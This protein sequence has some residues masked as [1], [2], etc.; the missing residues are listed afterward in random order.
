M[1]P[2]MSRMPADK[3]QE[4]RCL[5]LF[6]LAWRFNG[7]EKT[8]QWHLTHFKEFG[9]SFTF[10]KDKLSTET[11]AFDDS[12]LVE[13]S[14][15]WPLLKDRVSQIQA[16][17]LNRFGE[18]LE[19]GAKDIDDDISSVAQSIS[20]HDFGEELN[21]LLEKVNQR[22]AGDGDGIDCAGTLGHLRTFFEKLHENVGKRI[23]ELRGEIKDNTDLEKFGQAIDYLAR[24]DVITE[25]FKVLAKGVY[26][27]L[28]REGA[29]AVSTTPVYV[30]LCRNFVIEYAVVLIHETERVCNER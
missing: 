14:Y 10:L 21:K 3:A 16:E 5:R 2:A 8:V 7:P 29:H 19:S 6:E 12:L 1:H 26:G 20:R 17:R 30:R 24:K 9:A 13:V 11:A 15:T 22:I 25:N 28:C 18:S 4:I 23:G 27:V